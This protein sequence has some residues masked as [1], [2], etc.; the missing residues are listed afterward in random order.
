M[1]A[2]FGIQLKFSYRPKVK[3]SSVS[4]L[5]GPFQLKNSELMV[6]QCIS[7]LDKPCS[8]FL[9]FFYSLWVGGR[10]NLLNVEDWSRSSMGD[11]PSWRNLRPSQVIKILIF[12]KA[13]P[14]RHHFC[15][16]K[17]QL[18]LFLYNCNNWEVAWMSD[19]KHF[20]MSGFSFLI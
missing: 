8:L 5:W 19:L 13:D 17:A 10:S 2:V 3:S 11:V 18:W 4:S 16:I 14:P 1:C 15:Y 12:C 7:F 20:I 9:S 6:H